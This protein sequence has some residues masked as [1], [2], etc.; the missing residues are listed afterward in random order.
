MTLVRKPFEELMGLPRA[1]DRFFDE[2][3]FRPMRWYFREWEMPALDVHAT[4]AEFIVEA[5]LPGLKPEDVEITVD[6]ELLTIKGSYR[7]EDK[8]E[9]AGYLYREL[10]RGEF[11][12]TISL[13]APTLAE[14][15]KAEF[16][17]GLLTL[18]LPK[19]TEVKPHKVQVTAG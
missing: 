3:F 15:V 7:R 10:G 12:R 1:M 16:K 14:Q 6:G 13:P 19:A 5:A 11:T 2:P 4:D 9:E 8:A 17:D 18:K